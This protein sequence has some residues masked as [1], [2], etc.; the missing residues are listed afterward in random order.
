MTLPPNHVKALKRSITPTRM[1]TYLSETGGDDARAC[2][3]YLWDRDLQ[4][5]SA[6]SLSGPRSAPEPSMRMNFTGGRPTK[7]RLVD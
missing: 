3:L 5:I 2:E 7:P 6:L 4:L 1:S